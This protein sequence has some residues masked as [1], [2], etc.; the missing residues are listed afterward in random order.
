M[1]KITSLYLLLGVNAW[2]RK[3]VEDAAQMMAYISACKF[4]RLPTV[5]TCHA[6]YC[7]PADLRVCMLNPHAIVWGFPAVAFLLQ[8][9]H[10]NGG[11]DQ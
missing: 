9:P 10:R 7:V 1:V 5:P 11:T 2:T 3:V 8:Q 6:G 4:S